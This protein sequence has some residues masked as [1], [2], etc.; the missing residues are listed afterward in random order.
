MTIKRIRAADFRN[1]L[2]D[3]LEEITHNPNMAFEIAVYRRTVAYVVT[4]EDFLFLKRMKEEMNESIETTQI[5]PQ[6]PW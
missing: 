4:P 6:V 1:H 5:L 3:H 2:S